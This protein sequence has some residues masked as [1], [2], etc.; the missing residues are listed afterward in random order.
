MRIV[1]SV[2]SVVFRVITQ[3][4]EGNLEVARDQHCLSMSNVLLYTIYIKA[5]ECHDFAWFI[6][7]TLQFLLSH[8]FF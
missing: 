3:R 1:N 4:R 7:H 5:L 2:A 8:V 6:Q